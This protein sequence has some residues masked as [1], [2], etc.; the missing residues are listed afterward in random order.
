[1]I[2]GFIWAISQTLKLF[3]SDHILHKKIFKT[4][5]SH[6]SL[7][8]VTQ[9][10]NDIKVSLPG[11]LPGRLPGKQNINRFGLIDEDEGSLIDPFA[12]VSNV[13]HFKIMVTNGLSRLM[14]NQ[15]IIFPELS[16][17][18]DSQ[19]PQGIMI[20]KKKQL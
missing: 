4:T 6:S 15:K 12:K 8:T 2:C 19:Q 3:K 20:Q 17:V 5:S 9:S 10:I 18:K 7:N 11:S 13:L 16:K 14:K 1:M